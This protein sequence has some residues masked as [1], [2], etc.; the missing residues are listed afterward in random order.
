MV[1]NPAIDWR[2][3]AKRVV[4][5]WLDALP[6]DCQIDGIWGGQ[7][8]TGPDPGPDGLAGTA[9]DLSILGVLEDMAANDITLLVLYSGV[10]ENPYF[11]RSLLELWD[12]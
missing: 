11:S 5:A 4:V 10:E 12:D 6:H 2:S 8:S 1:N 7:L 9:D 3:G